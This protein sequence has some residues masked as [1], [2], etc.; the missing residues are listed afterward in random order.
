MAVAASQRN[1]KNKIDIKVSDGIAVFN[2]SHMVLATRYFSAN[3][4]VAS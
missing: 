4:L 2:E 1:I 3:V